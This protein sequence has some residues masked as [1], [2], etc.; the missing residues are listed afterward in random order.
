MQFIPSSYLRSL[1]IALAGVTQW[2]ACGPTNQTIA[3][4]IPSIGHMPGLYIGQ[5]PSRGQH[6]RCNHTLMFFSLFSPSLP[7]LKINK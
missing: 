2:I 7:S 5:V 6:A 1:E 4:S 3:S